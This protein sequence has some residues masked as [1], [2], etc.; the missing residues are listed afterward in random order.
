MLT[1]CCRRSRTRGGCAARLHCPLAICGRGL[2]RLGLA[3]ERLFLSLS[4]RPPLSLPV[5]FNH[6]LGQG[7]FKT[8]FKAYD[9]EEG[10]EVAWCRVSMDRMEKQLLM[11]IHQEVE[12]LKSL[13]HTN[14]LTFYSYF[15]TPSRKQ[16]V[17]ITEMMTSGTLKQY[18]NKAKR[19]KRKV[20]KKWCRQILSGLS[21]LHSNNII[22]RDLKCD[23]IFINGNT[24]EIKIGDFFFSLSLTTAADSPRMPHSRPF[25]PHTL[26]FFPHSSHISPDVFFS[27]D[28]GL[29]TLM[30]E[31]PAQS[32]LGTPEFMA[33]ELYD[34]LY[35]QK[36][37]VYA[38]GMCVLEMVTGEYPYSEC[39]NAAQI[40]RK[41]TQRSKPASLERILDDQTR[42]FI[43]LCLE[44]EISDRPHA[45]ELLEHAYLRPPFGGQ[46]TIDDKPV[47]M[48]PPKETAQFPNGAP[49]K[50]GGS[51]A[52]LMNLLKFLI[53]DVPI[54]CRN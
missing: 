37:D 1:S 51:N 19:V 7:A 26:P 14:I 47:E 23:N 6:V 43:S 50:G 53:F 32:V 2:C 48:L 52:W 18:I 35:D 45:A 41:V 29:S 17:F 3:G 9:D 42:D 5:Q 8:V 24:S 21:Y 49:H 54:F 33:P 25:P 38:F 28:L 44:H 4:R 39:L 20:V 36:V 13:S 31:G 16:M 10:V 22:H 46:G 12:I 27:G 34:E 15:D 11:Q 40:Y 30:K